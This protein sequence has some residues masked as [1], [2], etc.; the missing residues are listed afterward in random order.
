MLQLNCRKCKE[1]PITFSRSRNLPSP[2]NVEG[3][4]IIPVSK[5]KLLGVTINSTLTW[6]D[7]IEEIVKKA[8]RKQYFLVQLKK[9]KVP[10]REI[11]AYY[12]ACIRSAIDYACPKFHYSLPKYLQEDL[13]RI[14]KRALA[15]I[16][17][18]RRYEDALSLAGLAMASIYT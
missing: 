13:E 8:S 10:A 14:Q 16:Y 9:A 2:V 3:S 7:H 5:V 12:C 15:C 18:G 1:L 11:V 4:T 17:P 6:N